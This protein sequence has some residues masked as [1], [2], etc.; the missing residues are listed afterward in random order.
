MDVKPWYLSKTIL[1]QLLG[2]LAIIVGLFSPS[3]GSF[4]RDNFSEVGA[5]WAIINVVLRLVSK[6]QLSIS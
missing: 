2:A 6:D 4:I 3:V 1:V 5:A